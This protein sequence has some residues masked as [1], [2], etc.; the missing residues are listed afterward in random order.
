MLP[1]CA[2]GFWTSKESVRA[3]STKY[4]DLDC[5]PIRSQKSFMNPE[6]PLA[7]VT[8]VLQPP[9]AAQYGSALE[10]GFGTSTEQKTTGL[11]HSHTGPLLIELATKLSIAMF[12]PKSLVQATEPQTT[13]LSLSVCRK[14]L[15]SLRTMSRIGGR[16]QR[17]G[18]G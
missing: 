2:I 6:A 11:N 4:L 18:R 16:L 14:K 17:C 12:M 15:R 7:D 10:V 8:N 1:S 13:L 5:C 3:T 9:Q